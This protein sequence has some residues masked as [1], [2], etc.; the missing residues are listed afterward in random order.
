MKS[1]WYV[2]QDFEFQRIING[3]I[4]FRRNNKLNSSILSSK[5]GNNQ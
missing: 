4:N 2:S 5:N 1:N 3:E